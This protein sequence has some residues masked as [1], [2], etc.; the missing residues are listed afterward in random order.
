MDINRRPMAKKEAR[1]IGELLALGYE[2][3]RSL[4]EDYLEIRDTMEHDVL[5]NVYENDSV[6][7]PITNWPY[8]GTKPRGH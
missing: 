1:I 8:L 2:H 4:W 6:T 7:E 3:A 5:D